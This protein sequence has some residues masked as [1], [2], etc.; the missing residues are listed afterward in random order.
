VLR[1]LVLVGGGHAHVG[2]LRRFAMQPEPG[3]RLTLISRG[4]SSP[5]SGMLPGYIAGHYSWDEVHIDLERLCRFARATLIRAEVTGIDRAG[6]RVLLGGRPPIAYDLLSLNLG[7]TPKIDVVPGAAQHAVGVKPIDGFNQRWLALDG[8]LAEF[9]RRASIAVVGAGAAGVELALALHERLG[10]R[11]RD[12]GRPADAPLIALYGAN[13]QVLPTHA[14][15]VRRRVLPLLAAKGIVL[16]LGDPV[17]QV[18]EGALVWRGETFAHDEIVWVTQAGGA[19]WLRATGLA[20]DRNGF[21]EVESSLR[22]R[23]DPK[24]FAAGDVAAF[25]GR[26]L[27]KAGVFAVRMGRPLA[28]N[29]RR[30]LRGEPLRPYRPQ[31]H[32]LSLLTTGGRH[33]V[34]SRGPFGFSGNWVWH[35]KDWID[36]RFMRRFSEFDMPRETMSQAAPT[37]GHRLALD[38][39]EA[40]QALSVLAMRCGG[41]GA[42]VGA[43]ILSRV[44]ARLD[45]VHHPDVLIGLD[46]PDDAAV[47]ALPAGQVLVQSVD[48]FRSFI[49]DPWLFGQIAATHALSDLFAMGATPQSAAALVT[50]PPALDAKV[51]ELLVQLMSGAL[52]VLRDAGC[53]LVGGHTAEGQELAMGF[54]VNGTAPA[55]L[56][57]L[58]RKSGLRPGDA[59]VLTKPLGTGTL[60][61]AR[62]ALAAR[63]HWIDE[64]VTSMLRSNQAAAQCLRD[65]G[66]RACTDVTG[67]GLLGHV[68]EMVRA[69][70]VGARLDRSAVP[71]LPGAV[72]TIAAGH[73]SSLHA[74]NLRIATLVAGFES[75]QADPRVQL[76]FDPQTS[77]GLVAGVPADRALECVAALRAL[78]YAQASVVGEVVPLVEGEPLLAVH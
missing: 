63:G 20:L 75:I 18:I 27:E 11:L 21:I 40:T 39:S 2:V 70:G 49:D 64:A 53:A 9:P 71:A 44:L 66:V 56:D 29:L 15:S 65:H 13:P 8:R 30:A 5:Y 23:S 73:R 41:C 4:S 12:A 24:V 68:S 25:P 7:S 78:G 69:S 47:I 46:A 52:R 50:V 62:E 33:A 57:T 42:K 16:R 19:P 74:G 37:Q 59:L 35:W 43:D 60:L 10:A 76:L 36:R 26:S 34:G 28:D 77:G 14:G 1:D 58:M 3:V 54:A 38:P 45:P 55:S 22:S 67:F 51:E 32:W 72:T 48:F 61:V 31:R 6:Q 17:T